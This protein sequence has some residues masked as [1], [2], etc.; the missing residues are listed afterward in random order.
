MPLWIVDAEL[1]GEVL[2]MALQMQPASSSS[3]VVGQQHNPVVWLHAHSS[4]SAAW[5]THHW[6]GMRM[7]ITG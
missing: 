2:Y 3:D 4:S 1:Q 5:R 7:G 6:M